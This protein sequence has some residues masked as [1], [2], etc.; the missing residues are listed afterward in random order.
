V[1]RIA[2]WV[3]IVTRL[4]Q[5]PRYAMHLVLRKLLQ[6]QR[7]RHIAGRASDDVAP[8]LGYDLVLTW[9]CNLRCR[10]CMQ[11]GRH[12]WCHRLDDE[13]VDEE[14]PLATIE[15]LVDASRGPG[16]FFVL[17]GGEPLLYTEFDSLAALL[18][19]R[20]CFATVCTNGTLLDQHVEAIRGNPYLSF[21][22]ALDGLATANDAIRGQGVFRKV[23]QNIRTLK[24]ARGSPY[25]G[26]EC[27]VLP[28]NLSTLAEFCREVA[29]LGAD[30]IVLNLAWF[31]SEK[32]ARD[33]EA[34]TRAHYAVDPV[35]H[36]GYVW[37]YELDRQQFVAQYD[38]IARERWPV[39]IS[40][41]PPLKR[42]D[43]I[44]DYMDRPEDPLGHTFCYKQW[45]RCDV[46]PSGDV[47]TCK[48][49]P[50]I[51]AGHVRDEDVNRAWNSDRYR[52]F[53]RLITHTPLPVCSKCNALYLYQPNRSVL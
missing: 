39:Q 21:V 9:K 31:I 43:Q 19:R 42:A 37:N 11:W 17:F 53:R 30:W 1:R 22:I 28:D 34:L 44:H 25:I 45:L 10:M 7:C 12:G 20:R 6:Y 52:Q 4:A 41:M 5:H 40:W 49:F 2:K 27:T 13:L 26:V 32:Q 51:V 48:Q 46:L 50:D 8:P 33:Y 3:P 47:V 24:A 14:L 29:R 38:T 35:S 15:R 36:S 18:R 23:T 16:T